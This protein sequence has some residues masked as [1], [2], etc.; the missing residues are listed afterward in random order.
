MLNAV[1]IGESLDEHDIHG[2]LLNSVLSYCATA[3]ATSAPFPDRNTARSALGF[4]HT[5]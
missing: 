1:R 3:A 2:R 5:W 4:V